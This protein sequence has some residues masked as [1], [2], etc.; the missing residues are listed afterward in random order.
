MR[1]LGHIW[2]LARFRF[3]LYLLSGLLDSTLVYLL[4]LV[5]GLIVQSSSTP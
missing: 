3:G 5:P 2:S 1:S 4:P